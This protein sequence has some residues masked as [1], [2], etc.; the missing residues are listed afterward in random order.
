M[1]AISA[2]GVWVF[3]VPI[4]ASTVAVLFLKGHRIESALITVAALAAN[5][6]NYIIKA[7]VGRPRPTDDLVQTMQDFHGFA[8][9]SGHVVHHVVF[10][11]TLVVMLTWAMKP[12]LARR[13]IC[14]GLVLA[15]VAIGLSRIY[16]GA[17]YVGDV[18]GGYL[19]GAGM[20]AFFIA[21]WRMWL[22]RAPGAPAESPS[23]ESATV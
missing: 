21:L 22:D 11:G 7:I 4:V 8:F 14:G 17:H 12:G 1:T 18:F 23:M 9:P 3:S 15:L 6:A 10:L 16:L 5:G 19:F 13:L 2:P 20:V